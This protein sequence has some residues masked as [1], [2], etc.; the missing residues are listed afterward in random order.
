MPDPLHLLDGHVG[1]ENILIPQDTPRMPEARPLPATALREAGL[2]ELFG[3]VNS[4]KLLE[5]ALCPS[6]GDGSVLQPQEFS[7]CLKSS[8]EALKDS[9]QIAVRSFV[10]AE[11]APL[12][13]NETLLQAYSGLLVGG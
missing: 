11:L 10:S 7:H 1:I 3:T 9:Q 5:Q 12:L 8:L 2:E 4:D 6:V 13:E